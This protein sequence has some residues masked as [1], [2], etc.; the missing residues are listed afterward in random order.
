MLRR[1][2]TGVL[3]FL[4]HKQSRLAAPVV[5]MATGNCTFSATENCTL[6]AGALRSERTGAG[7]YSARTGCVLPSRA[8]AARVPSRRLR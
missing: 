5:S 7:R 1:Q 6:R 8:D 3:P 4:I 2:H